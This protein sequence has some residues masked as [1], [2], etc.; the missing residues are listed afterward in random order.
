MAEERSFGLFAP[1]TVDEDWRWSGAS[2]AA[3]AARTHSARRD[4]GSRCALSPNSTVRRGSACE[5]D[6]RRRADRLKKFPLI[7]SGLVLEIYS[8]YSG[9]AFAHRFQT[10][11]LLAKTLQSCLHDLWRTPPRWVL[12]SECTWLEQVVPACLIAG[13]RLASRSVNASLPQRARGLF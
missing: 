7:N 4:A 3:L 1:A 8:G 12:Q 6:G 5:S 2:R 10:N 11:S 9:V 13:D